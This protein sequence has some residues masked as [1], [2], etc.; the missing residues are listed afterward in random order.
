MVSTGKPS[1]AQLPPYP[2]P[3][4]LRSGGEGGRGERWP[5]FGFLSCFPSESPQPP[6]SIS[7]PDTS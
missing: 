1:H 5:G 3:S 7:K 2:R 6:N 4:S